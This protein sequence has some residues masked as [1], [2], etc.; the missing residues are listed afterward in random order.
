MRKVIDTLTFYGIKLYSYVKDLPLNYEDIEIEKIILNPLY[1]YSCQCCVDGFYQQYLWSKGKNYTIRLGI[2]NPKCRIPPQIEIERQ[3]DHEIR[4]IVLHPKHHGFSLLDNRLEYVYQFAEDHELP[5]IIHQ[6]NTSEVRK[7]LQYK[8]NIVLVNS[9]KIVKGDRIFY[10][11]ER[12]SLSDEIYGSGSPYNGK[13]II[14][15][16]KE[17]L[18]SYNPYLYYYLPKKLFDKD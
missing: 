4:G 11:S 13:G 17:N 6:P 18:N 5:L 8:V 2:Y 15:A 10:I 7:M 1:K 9:E 16:L 12:P 14:E 3:Y